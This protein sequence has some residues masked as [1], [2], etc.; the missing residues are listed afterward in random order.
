M[1]RRDRRTVFS[2][3]KEPN[4]TIIFPVN[5]WHDYAGFEASCNNLF[6]PVF[7]NLYSD[8]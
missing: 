1:Y 2:R 3:A 8:K 6:L 7:S 5:T 4:V